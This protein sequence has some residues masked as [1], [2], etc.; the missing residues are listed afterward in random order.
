MKIDKDWEFNEDVAKDFEKHIK[1]S[2]PGYENIQEKVL[3]LCE[4]FIRKNS[5]VYDLGCSKG[6]LLKAIK[7]KYSNREFDLVGI[8]NQIKMK[9]E[10]FDSGEIQFLNC[11]L[12]KMNSFDNA[13]VIISLFTLQFLG[14]EERNCV[15][16]SIYNSLKKG[17]VF[18]WG[19]KVKTVN[20]SFSEM[21]KSILLEYKLNNGISSEEI[22]T[23][24]RSIR[25]VMRLRTN[26]ENKETLENLGYSEIEVIYK[27]NDFVLYGAIK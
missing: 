4:W 21:N 1:N 18:F 13:S 14:F 20:S 19:E 3:E 2:I 23:K 5:V 27:E 10:V 7:D 6:N 24:D 9:S 12:E 25:G 26:E 8:D 16:K 15:Q 17:D 22:L 11:D